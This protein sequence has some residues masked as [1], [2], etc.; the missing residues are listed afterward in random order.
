MKISLPALLALIA[1]GGLAALA[2][3]LS[4]LFPAQQGLFNAIFA[5]TGILA[6]VAGIIVQAIQPAAKIVADAP[7][8]SPTTGAQVATNISSSSSLLPPKG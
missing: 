3:A 2:P 1:G 4:A 7:V 8:V 6:V 5:G